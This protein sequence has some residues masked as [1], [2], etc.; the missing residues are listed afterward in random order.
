M[1]Q[2]GRPLNWREWWG[3]ESTELEVAG[4]CS[5][6]GCDPRI[7]H[8]EGVVDRMGGIEGSW[9]GLT[10]LR[11]ASLTGRRVKSGYPLPYG[12]RLVGAVVWSRQKP[13]QHGIQRDEVAT[14]A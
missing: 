1:K 10:T 3:A 6:G 13:L 12:G 9:A 4:N 5:G 14:K 8:Q 2:Q 11:I 7:D